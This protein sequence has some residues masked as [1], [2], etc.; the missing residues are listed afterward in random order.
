MSFVAA[1]IGAAGAIGGALISSRGAKS[2]A[3]SQ[4]AS[5][6]QAIDE[7]RRQFDLTRDDFAPYRQTGVNALQQLA[8]D[9]NRMPTSAEVMSD[10]GYQFGQEQGQRAIDRKIASMGGRVSGQAIKAAARFGTDYATAGYGAAY[11]RRQ[12]RLNRLAALAGVGQT[13]TGSSAFAGQNSANNISGLISSQGDATGASQ[14]AQGSIWGNAAN[15]LGAMGQRAFGGGYGNAFGGYR[16][17][18]PYRNA[19][20]F[21]GGE[22]E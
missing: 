13:A 11:Q 1:A 7:Q 3:E 21:G 15:Q 18:D 10:P 17:D 9:I 19:G 16:A 6:G 12:D 20:Y 22:G 2:A 4:Q 14:M 5:T 8:G